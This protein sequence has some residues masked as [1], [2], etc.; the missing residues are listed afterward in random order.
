MAILTMPPQVIEPEFSSDEEGI[1]YVQNLALRG[2]SALGSTLEVSGDF[3][4]TPSCSWYRVSADGKAV[5]IEGALEQ[6][7]QVTSK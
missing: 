2:G 1:E 4:G 7:R 5:V 6:S 3:V